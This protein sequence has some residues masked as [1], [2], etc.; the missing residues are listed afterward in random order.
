MY[1][2]WTSGSHVSEGVGGLDVMAK[3]D[4]LITSKTLWT[5]GT[6][7][8][9]VMLKGEGSYKNFQEQWKI[10]DTQ[11]ISIDNNQFLIPN[12]YQC[13]NWGWKITG[14]QSNSTDNNQFLIP[15]IYRCPN[16]GLKVT[17]WVLMLKVK[18]NNGIK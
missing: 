4:M 17:D 11:F 16:W 5:T 14:T 6:N 1:F 9:Y 3:I 13:P 7:N 8:V 12:I 18:V 15:N 2:I 10:T